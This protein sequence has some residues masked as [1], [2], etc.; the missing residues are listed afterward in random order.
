MGRSLWRC[1][2]QSLLSPGPGLAS[3]AMSIGTSLLD[4]GRFAW[5]SHRWDPDSVDWCGGLIENRALS[6]S[7]LL[8]WWNQYGWARTR[9]RV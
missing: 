4:A 9:C 8:C 2:L 6:C 1:P 7:Y 5:D 3:G